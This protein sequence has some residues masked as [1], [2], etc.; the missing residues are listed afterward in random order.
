ME[1]VLAYAGEKS[2]Y[3]GTLQ[4][5]AAGAYELR[6]LAID[7]ANTNFGMNSRKLVVE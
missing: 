2:T 6:L 7:S 5:P 3:S 4:A 1:S